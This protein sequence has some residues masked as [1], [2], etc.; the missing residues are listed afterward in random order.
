MQIKYLSV[1]DLPDKKKLKMKIRPIQTEH[2]F[3]Q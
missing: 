2:L 3:K 1:K